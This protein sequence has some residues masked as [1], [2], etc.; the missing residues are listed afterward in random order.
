MASSI[1]CDRHA[2][3][4]A[5]IA[6]FGGSPASTLYASSVLTL[7]VS[8]FCTISTVDLSS[9]VDYICK[10]RGL[11]CKHRTTMLYLPLGIIATSYKVATALSNIICHVTLVSRATSASTAGCT[12]HLAAWHFSADQA[13]FVF[14]CRSSTFVACYCYIC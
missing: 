11:S 8:N 12:S 10:I 5:H 2:C 3:Q 1:E 7:S 14:D 13:A 4:S 9:F 6:L